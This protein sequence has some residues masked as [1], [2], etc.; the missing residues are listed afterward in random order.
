VKL[1][2]ARQWT[3]LVAGGGADES[4]HFEAKQAVSVGHG[5]EAQAWYRHRRCRR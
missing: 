2:Q 3:A 5:G 1:G 4:G